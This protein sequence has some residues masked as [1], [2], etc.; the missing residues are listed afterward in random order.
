MGVRQNDRFDMPTLTYKFRV[1][2]KHASELNRQ[3]RAV[4]LVWNFCNETQKHAVSWGR[5]WL[6]GYDL[7]KLTS[8]S[9]ED[10]NLHSHTVQ[11]VCLEYEKAR[12]T[13]K[14]SSLRWR[15]KKSLGWVPFNT[16]HVK[17]DGNAF[18]FRGSR[19][20]VWMSR[21]VPDTI[22]IG[23]G[24]F[25]QDSK[26][27]WY[28]N[29]TVDVLSEPSGGLATIGIDLGLKSFLTISNGDS[30]ESKKFY[31]DVE[32]K[33]AS[34]QRANKKKLVKAI[35]AKI[36]NRRKDFLHKLSTKL[37]KENASIFVGNVNASGLAKT[38][39]AKSVM[40]AGWS[41][42][43]KMLEYKAIRLQVLFAEVNESYTTQAC[44]GCGSI[45][46]PKGRAGLNERVWECG[47]CGTV[48][49]RDV[50]AAKNILARGLASLAEG[51]AIRRAY[52]S[53]ES[54]VVKH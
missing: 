7:I 21:G 19:Y 33:L 31:R 53:D 51:A 14:K 27:R 12:K 11:R 35:H 29:C 15:G 10:L 42:F 52:V 24:S 39:M 38:K 3:A 50:N 2:D 36:A 22:K 17:F 34:A 26:G 4:N 48:H 16:G 18:V 32:Q 47:D 37:V 6:S 30:V 13:H 28:I 41:T 43:R 20:K 40:D 54:G 9:G 44:S 25:N 23:V 5:K 1:K 45:A 8:G 49:D 46:G